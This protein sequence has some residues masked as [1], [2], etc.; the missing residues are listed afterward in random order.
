MSRVGIGLRA[1]HYEAILARRPALGFVEVH[2]ENFFGGGAPLAWL[3][4]FACAYPLSFHGVGLSLGSVDPLDRDHLARIAALVRRFDPV[5]VSE[6][7]SWSSFGGRHAH[8]LLPMPLTRAAAD[9]LVARIGAVQDALGRRILVENVSSYLA[10]AEGAMAEWQFVADVVS[11]AG[12]ALLLDVNNAWVSAAN[13]GFDARRY[14]DALA[15]LPIDEIHVAGHEATPEGLVDTH[16]APVCEA[17]W[18]L[19]AAAIA[20]APEAAT[21]VEWD[22]RIPPLDVLLAEAGRAATVRE[23]AL[24]RVAEAA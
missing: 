7:L 16:A 3:Q 12:C 4:R 18:E 20:R 6:H 23:A 9:H 14:V 5:L 8:D 11:R 2:T 1:P 13:A 19:Y 21:L 24:R 15:G 17:V 22:A 10:P